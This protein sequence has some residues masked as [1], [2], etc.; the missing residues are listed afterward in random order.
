MV[1]VELLLV[2]ALVER[3]VAAKAEI[4]VESVAVP[5]DIVAM[6]DKDLRELLIMKLM[7][8]AAVVV[9]APEQIL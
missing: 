7:D 8:L 6:E 5:E 4:L 9:E 3:V 2:E 1:E